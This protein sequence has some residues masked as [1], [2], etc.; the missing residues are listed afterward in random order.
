M[1]LRRRPRL[2][3]WEMTGLPNSLCPPMAKRTKQVVGLDIDPAGVAVAQVSVNGHVEIQRAAFAELESGVVRDGEVTDVEA[4]TETLKAVWRQHKGLGKRVRVGVANQKIV[5]RVI[6]L[7][8]LDDRK[9]LEAALRFQAQDQI[10]MPLDNAV[11]DFHPPG[12]ADS[13]AGP[14]Q[15]AVVVAPRRDMIE[16]VVRAVRD[17]GLRL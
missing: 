13:A 4:L 2:P 11:L 17:A 3:M 5:V 8:P 9:E 7:P 14:K 15:R 6:D 16:R 1:G 10:P 12:I